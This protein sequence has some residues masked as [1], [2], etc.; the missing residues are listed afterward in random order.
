MASL[1]NSVP[2]IMLVR[3][4]TLA[5]SSNNGS[6]NGSDLPF[7]ELIAQTLVDDLKGEVRL[8]DWKSLAY[9]TV[10]E[11]FKDEHSLFEKVSQGYHFLTNDVG[12]RELLV[13]SRHGHE[14]S[15]C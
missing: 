1:L 13:E 11:K 10:A 7:N 8:E 15:T 6:G 4:N 12:L 2:Q 9:K 3:R 14:A 5:R